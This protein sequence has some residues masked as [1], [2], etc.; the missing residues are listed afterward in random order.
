MRFLKNMKFI[1]CVIKFSL[2]FGLEYKNFE[3]NRDLGLV[4]EKRTD[5]I[6]TTKRANFEIETEMAIPQIKIASGC[7]IDEQL[8]NS[9]TKRLGISAGYSRIDLNNKVNIERVTKIIEAEIEIKNYKIIEELSKR[10]MHYSFNETKKFESKNNATVINK[11]NKKQVKNGYEEKF[12]DGEKI[13]RVRRSLVEYWKSGGV[14]NILTGG[15]TDKKYDENNQKIKKLKK[16]QE[17]LLKNTEK[18]FF[19]IQYQVNEIQERLNEAFCEQS[20]GLLEDV[21]S[22]EIVT[23]QNMVELKFESALKDCFES[24]VPQAIKNFELQRICEDIIG[25]SVICR[26]PNNLFKCKNKDIL[27]KNQKIIHRMDIEFLL[28]LL[29][30]Q[31]FVVHTI[32]VAIKPFEYSQFENNNVRLFISKEKKAVSFIKCQKRRMLEI[33]EIENSSRIYGKSECM[34]ALVNQNITKAVSHCRTRRFLD[35]PCLYNKIDDL[36]VLSSYDTVT[37]K[38]LTN[39]NVSSKKDNVI[40][41]FKGVTPI[42]T[43]NVSFECGDI[44]Y[45]VV[46]RGTEK[47]SL[48]NWTIQFNIGG[49][50]EFDSDL[51]PVLFE[52]K[53]MDD[54][55]VKSYVFWYNVC[56]IIVYTILAVMICRRIYHA[57]L[58][59]L[60]RI[61][62]AKQVIALEG[63]A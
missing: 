13:P 33:C 55:T 35:E 54:V 47:I 36:I 62:L 16:N 14:L 48:G 50:I 43:Q 25:K 22:F 49:P 28:P 5:L 63:T 19:K 37:V 9:L 41:K 2:V 58:W 59:Y 56:L 10:F 8:L 7:P 40:G 26:Y 17:L 44:L 38:K 52:S 4:L 27:I 6:L 57:I 39:E 18:K 23:I 11:V 3:I 24:Y 31:P 61:K 29:E 34:E 32:P 45:Q 12:M 21:V 1:F 15:Y 42:V 46:N 60:E 51:T 20:K 30:Y 53:A